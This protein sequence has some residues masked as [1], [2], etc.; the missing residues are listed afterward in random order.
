MANIFT[1]GTSK[2]FEYKHKAWLRS[3]GIPSD[4]LHYL[5]AAEVIYFRRISPQDKS[6][7]LYDLL[8]SFSDIVRLL[9][10]RQL[11]FLGILMLDSMEQVG[12][13]RVPFDQAAMQQSDIKDRFYRYFQEEVTGVA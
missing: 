10:R 5:T 12:A 3:P 9:S 4:P 2:R 7:K 6:P 8:F 11:V 13:A 1:S